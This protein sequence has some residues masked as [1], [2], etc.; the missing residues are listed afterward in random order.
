M[1]GL[2]LIPA[3]IQVRLVHILL[4]KKSLFFGKRYKRKFPSS[5][6]S[7]QSPAAESAAMR[8]PRGTPSPRLVVVV[9][10]AAVVAP[11]RGACVWY[12]QCGG[13]PGM[14]RNCA[15]DGPPRAL[16]AGEAHYLLRRWCSHLGGDEHTVETCCDL[17][18][19]RALDTKIRMA[20]TFLDK[21][22]ACMRNFVGHFCDFNCGTNQSAFIKIQELVSEASGQKSV[23]TID[24]HVTH[25]SLVAIYESCASVFV[26]ATGQLAMDIICGSWGASMCSA[27]RSR[28]TSGLVARWFSFMGDTSNGYVPFQV[29]YKL[30][31]DGVV[32]GVIPLDSPTTPCQGEADVSRRGGGGVARRAVVLAEPEGPR[33]AAAGQGSLACTCVD[34]PAA[35]AADWWC[36]A[37]GAPLFLVGSMDGGVLVL[38][39]AFLVLS[40]TFL[41]YHCYLLHGPVSFLL[42]LT[43][44]VSLSGGPATPRPEGEDQRGPQRSPQPSP[45]RGRKRGPEAEAAR[46]GPAGQDDRGVEARSESSQRVSLEDGGAT[47]TAFER[48][49][50]T[51]DHGLESFFSAWGTLCAASPWSFLLLA[52]VLTAALGSGLRRVNI[53]TDPIELWADPASRSRQER[54]YFEEHFE[55]FYRSEQVIVR[56]VGLDRVVHNTSNGLLEFGPAFNREFLASALDLQ[57]RIKK[58]GQVEGEGLEKICYAPF[59][60]ARGGP[61]VLDNCLVLSV[62]GYFQDSAKAFNA[63]IEDPNNFTQNYLDTL[64]KCFQNP[65]NPECFAVYG[66]PVDPAIALGGFLGPGDTLTGPEQYR[67]ATAVILTLLVHNHVDRRALQPAL[68]WEAKFVSFMVAWSR[69]ERPAYMDVAFSTD[70]SVEDELDRVS[71]SDAS[72]ILISYCAMFVY[73]ALSLG[74]VTS[75][76][77]LPVDSK[78]TLGLGG[79]LTVASA[80]VCSVG[81]YAYVGVAAT[82][83]VVE[84]VPFLVL[85]VGVDNIFI[86]VMTHE[87]TARLPRESI[88]DHIGRVMGQVGP[89]M[90]LTTLSEICCFLLGAL[91]TMPAIR[92]FALY[93]GGALVMDFLFQMTCFA[94]R[95]DVCCCWHLGAGPAGAPQ[96]D[97]FT[98]LSQALVPG[99]AE[100]RPSRSDEDGADD[101]DPGRHGALFAFFSRRYAPGL[102]LEDVRAF[103]VVAFLLWLC[104]SLAVLRHVP[105]GLDQEQA[106]PEDSYLLKYFRFL[107]EYLCIGPPV[108]FVVKEGLNYSSPA[109]QNTLCAGPGCSKDSLAA[110]T[111]GAAKTPDCSRIARPSTSW[112]DDYLNWLG[113]SGCCYENKTTGQFCPHSKGSKCKEC[114]VPFDPSTSRPSAADFNKYVP[115]FLEDNPDA[116]CAVAGHA[117]HSKAVMYSVTADGSVVVGASNFMAFHTILKHP[118]DYYTALREARHLADRIQDAVND[119]LRRENVSDTVDVFAYSTFYVFY[120]QYLTMWADT[121]TGL[122][123]SL[124][125][126]FVVCF[127]LMGLDSWSALYIVVTITMILIDLMAFMYWADISL[128]AVSLV[129]LVMCIGISIE[130]CG[131]LVHSFA[132]SNKQSRLE[133]AADALA[134]MGSCVSTI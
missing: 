87:R 107:K 81:F 104:C 86:L 36:V 20:S 90:L 19:L 105:V 42:L 88:S 118:S 3:V 115:Y 13:E 106:M 18:Q 9:V 131:H 125:A 43:H 114:R 10:L 14:P 94:S 1:K 37:S 112:V 85:A 127:V 45:Q 67:E 15:Y 80:V 74:R 126:I 95:L 22:P 16:P 17:D 70:R 128:N 69:D 12:G 123:I 113:H 7:Q 111:F 82:L 75:L 6:A 32:D 79:V 41:A 71:R 62:W 52:M 78:V 33:R 57:D 130:F 68:E 49:G 117:A 132:L 98:W 40:S 47:A 30:S 110:Q 51:L 39:V 46:P 64:Q 99:Q 100:G 38:L 8:A 28:S 60:T 56:A 21:C 92:A 101:D 24:L 121:A 27:F 35:C 2:I 116:S 11:G 53:V 84:V 120:E 129:N 124:A 122:S 31:D 66:G 119:H 23:K 61:A 25:K 54:D 29:N 83:I 91:S 77:R 65:Y 59:V 44:A 72:T 96:Q 89:S 63:T 97:F 102:L 103:V 133:R 134:Q 55:P 34:C 26:P 93:A 108:Y 48:A 109:A 73:V 76:R 4:E 5:F 58:I 50:A